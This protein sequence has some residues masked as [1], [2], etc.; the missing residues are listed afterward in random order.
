MLEKTCDHEWMCRQTSGLA[1]EKTVVNQLSEE[2][3]NKIE[4][5]S[6]ATT[7]VCPGGDVV[8]GKCSINFLSGQK[9]SQEFD[10]KELTG[11]LNNN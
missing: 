10:F 2:Q 11:K 7:E 9:N 1:G 6:E 3:V 4:L 5:N 8:C